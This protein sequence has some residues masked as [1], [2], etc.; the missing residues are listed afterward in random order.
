M[1]GRI[2]DNPRGS[3]NDSR[4]LSQN[5]AIGNAPLGEPK[6]PGSD[7]KALAA[8]IATDIL[9]RFLNHEINPDQTDHEIR[10][11]GGG[12][13]SL[14]H[15]LTWKFQQAVA[16][17]KA[18]G[19][20]QVDA[21][22]PGLV[23]L[24]KETLSGQALENFNNQPIIADAVTALAADTTPVISTSQEAQKAPDIQI[25][26]PIVMS[27]NNQTNQTPGDD[28]QTGAGGVTQLVQT[29]DMSRFVQE[30]EVDA[31]INGN[32]YTG[33][34]TI[35]KATYEHSIEIDKPPGQNNSGQNI[36]QNN[37]QNNADFS[38]KAEAQQD[39]TTV[40]SGPLDFGRHL[41]EDNRP[42]L[43]KI[44]DA[45]VVG[46]RDSKNS[47]DIVSSVRVAAL[48]EVGKSST[49]QTFIN[50][51]GDTKRPS[52]RLVFS[53]ITG[54]KK[55]PQIPAR[56]SKS[57]TKDS[58]KESKQDPKPSD[59]SPKSAPL[60][61]LLK[62]KKQ[63]LAKTKKSPA[64]AIRIKELQVVVPL[65]KAKLTKIKKPGK[66]K[67]KVARPN[68]TPLAKVRINLAPKP[69]VQQNTA[70][71]SSSSK[72]KPKLSLVVPVKPAISSKEATKLAQSKSEPK[73][74]DEVKLKT[75]QGNIK[76]SKTEKPRDVVSLIKSIDSK[77]S[78]PKPNGKKATDKEK[79]KAKFKNILALILSKKRS[80]KVNRK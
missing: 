3:S 23:E 72:A 17:E 36:D 2:V 42:M 68:P 26:S 50:P 25:V 45:P 31:K 80:K 32:S 43:L 74:K 18:N 47:G 62:I 16:K 41:L 27:Q 22:L 29:A 77:A 57:E 13:K 9:S 46:I 76:N 73:S 1:A 59:D 28:S 63:K 60:A 5:P 35:E 52:L 7:K 67:P 20:T 70:P 15:A 61:K 51:D 55:S 11:S 54:E 4:S 8:G 49:D 66:T 48:S 44:D 37:Q 12:D 40:L 38:N 34:T 21:L 24:A 10:K 39:I 30:R 71:K 79:E 58:K 19:N 64:K 14:L 6:Q 56:A 33:Q 78:K 53:N 69:T 65:P 75:S